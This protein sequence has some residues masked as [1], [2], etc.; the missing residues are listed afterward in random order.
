MVDIAG[1]HLIDIFMM[2]VMCSEAHTVVNGSYGNCHISCDKSENAEC[3][4]TGGSS[5]SI[6]GH[7]SARGV[8]KPR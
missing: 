5:K 8:V 6:D 1:F 2:P 4:D 3:G 7:G